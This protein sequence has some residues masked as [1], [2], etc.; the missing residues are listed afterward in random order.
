MSKKVIVTASFEDVLPKVPV[1]LEVRAKKFFSKAGVGQITM[2]KKAN[3]IHA[4]L[5]GPHNE[6]HLTTKIPKYKPGGAVAKSFREALQR[7]ADLFDGPFHVRHNMQKWSKYVTLSI[8]EEE[9]A[10]NANGIE[11]G[12]IRTLMEMRD[13]TSY[14][15]SAK[16]AQVRQMFI[17]DSI[18]TPSTRYLKDHSATQ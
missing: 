8:I 7:G 9:W 3:V 12:R 6:M 15:L 11:V 16:T 10:S 14:D 4:F 18:A 2:G 1:T 5:Y 13:I 17:E